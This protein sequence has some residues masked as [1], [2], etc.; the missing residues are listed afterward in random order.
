[1]ES[2]VQELIATVEDL[3]I[4]HKNSEASQYLTISAGALQCGNEHHYHSDEIYK[5]VDRLLYEA[6][7]A[8]RN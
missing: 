5:A 4:E 1:M 3:Q 2:F 6:K 7:T 8:G